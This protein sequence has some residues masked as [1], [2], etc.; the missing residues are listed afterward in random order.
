MKLKEFVVS[1]THY[2]KIFKEDRGIHI[3]FIYIV[4]FI[5]N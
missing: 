5:F 3:M 4:F 2:F 1:K